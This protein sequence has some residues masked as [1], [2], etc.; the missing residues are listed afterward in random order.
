L[1]EVLLAALDD[2]DLKRIQMPLDVVA[3]LQRRY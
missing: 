2:A 3:K 1:L